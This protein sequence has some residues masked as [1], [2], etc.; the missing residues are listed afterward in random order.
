MIPAIASPSLNSATNAST[1]SAD[2]PNQKRTHRVDNRV[3]QPQR[4]HRCAWFLSPSHQRDQAAGSHQDRNPKQRQMPADRRR[5]RDRP[6]R[7]DQQRH[8]VPPDID[9]KRKPLSQRRKNL[10]PPGVDGDVLRGGQH[11]DAAPPPRR[12]RLASPPD[13]TMPAGSPPAPVPAAPAKATHAV[14][15][16]R[17]KAGTGGVWSSKG[18]HR[19]FSE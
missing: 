15:P 19:N 3:S 9:G 13:R 12:R 7:G 6:R 1:S 10:D 2:G 16:N 5:R 18:A 11:R 14:G 17:R 4:R 8:P